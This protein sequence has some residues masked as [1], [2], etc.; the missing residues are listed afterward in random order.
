MGYLV[1]VFEWYSSI[2]LYMYSYLDLKYTLYLKTY[3]WTLVHFPIRLWYVVLVLVQ[4]QYLVPCLLK[5][6][7]GSTKST[8]SITFIFPDCGTRWP[9]T[10]NWS[11]Y[12]EGTWV[13]WLTSCWTWRTTTWSQWERP[14]TYSYSTWSTSLAYRRSSSTSWS[15]WAKSQSQLPAWTRRPTL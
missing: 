12:F 8:H 2:Y 14:R 15:N 1:H 5:T 7:V 9:R 10:T 4:P 13:Q 11:G 3:T 6:W